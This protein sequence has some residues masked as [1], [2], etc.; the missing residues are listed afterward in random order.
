MKLAALLPRLRF[1]S[2]RPSRLSM[3]AASRMSRLVLASRCA[4]C[5]IWRRRGSRERWC[6]GQNIR[7]APLTRDEAAD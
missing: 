4:R 2:C 3:V 6:N 7:Y 1:Q 5:N